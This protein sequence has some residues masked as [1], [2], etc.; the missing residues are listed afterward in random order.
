[1]NLNK[2]TQGEKIVVGGG[3]L[4]ILDLILLAWHKIDG[5]A[6]A[7]IRAAGGDP[8][9]TGIEAP[10]G[11]YGLFA[12]LLAAVMVLQIIG[13]RFTKAKLPQPAIGWGK[14][15]LYLGCGVAGVVLLKLFAETNALSIGALLGVVLAGALAYGG[16]LISKEPSLS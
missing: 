14:V 7:A 2:L 6:G 11:G 9:I 16:F 10:N 3:I 13:A 4:F 5:L 1:M 8:T 15:H 12:V